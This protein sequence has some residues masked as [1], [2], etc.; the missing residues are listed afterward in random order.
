MKLCV[1]FVFVAGYW[2]TRKT[3]LPQRAVFRPMNNPLTTVCRCWAAADLIYLARPCEAVDSPN[4]S[5]KGAAVPHTHTQACTG[6]QGIWWKVTKCPFILL[7]PQGVGSVQ[8]VTPA[9]GQADF[10]F[11]SA[12]GSCCVNKAAAAPWVS[13]Q[14]RGNS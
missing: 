9:R 3:F 12:T 7:A 14:Q 4:A 8:H 1:G 11:L 10:L 2:L 6:R 13:S 5:P